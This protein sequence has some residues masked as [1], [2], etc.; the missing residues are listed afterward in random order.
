MKQI[1]FMGEVNPFFSLSKDKRLDMQKSLFNYQADFSD[2][3]N[4]YSKINFGRT[5]QMME[6]ISDYQMNMMM[7][8]PFAMGGG[9]PV[10]V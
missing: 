7:M 3:Y 4:P 9:C 10:M 6:T 1:S 8:N 5:K 2:K